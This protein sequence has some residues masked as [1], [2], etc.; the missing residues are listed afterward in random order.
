MGWRDKLNVARDTVDDAVFR[1][2][3][4]FVRCKNIKN[5]KQCDLNKGH[6]GKHENG[7][8]KW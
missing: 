6:K 4:R 8:V 7:K 2:T 1:V 3:D 5:G